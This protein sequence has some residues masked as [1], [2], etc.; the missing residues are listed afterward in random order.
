M[1]ADLVAQL[2]RPSP[3]GPTPRPFQVQRDDLAVFAVVLFALFLGLG[4]R[5]QALNASRSFALGDELPTLRYPAGWI[6]A[7]PEGLRFQ[8]TNPASASTFDAQ[9]ALAVRDLRADETLDLARAAWGLR[10]SEELTNYRELTAEPV[11]VLDGQPGLLTTYAYVADPTR[12]QGASGLPVVVQ[13]QDLLFFDDG[14]LVAVTLAADAGEW[15]VER[16]HFAIVLDSL[17]VQPIE[18][19]VLAT[20]TLTPEET[21]PAATPVEGSE[22]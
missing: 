12:P 6:T 10:R 22:E 17:N 13:A 2:R 21:T 18:T 5:S 8:A 20:P 4:I 15:A 14:R 7:E 16:T 9:V 19:D 11:T 1:I 3:T